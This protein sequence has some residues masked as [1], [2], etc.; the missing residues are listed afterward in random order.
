[1]NSLCVTHNNSR[2]G[3]LKIL[4]RKG[5]RLVNVPH[6]F[7]DRLDAVD[8]LVDVLFNAEDNSACVAP[9]PWTAFSMDCMA[10]SALFCSMRRSAI[11]LISDLW[12]RA[13][14]LSWLC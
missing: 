9:S 3:L 2:I 4:G 14:I 1:M 12:V 11:P 6:D 7:G 8:D 13:S 10:R 5:H